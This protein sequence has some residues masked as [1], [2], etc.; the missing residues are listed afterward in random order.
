VAWG[1]IR[2]RGPATAIDP[3]LSPPSPD[4]LAQRW[5]FIGLV[6]ASWLLLD[7]LFVVALGSLEPEM[8]A[9][10]AVVCICVIIFYM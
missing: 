3:A 5:R 2:F 1:S 4:I 9:S 10:L 8:F 7:Y 6:S